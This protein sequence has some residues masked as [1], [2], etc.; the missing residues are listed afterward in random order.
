VKSGSP[1]REGELKTLQK[2]KVFLF[3][4]SKLW[5]QRCWRGDTIKKDILLQYHLF[6]V[7]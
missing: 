3:S 4:I 5:S 2:C 7:L 6:Y 1:A